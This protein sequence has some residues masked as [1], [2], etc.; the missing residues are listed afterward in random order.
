MYLKDLLIAASV[1]S[2]IGSKGSILLFG[3][4]TA[5]LSLWLT[6]A[7]QDISV[8]EVALSNLRSIRWWVSNSISSLGVTSSGAKSDIVWSVGEELVG[9][10]WV[11]T[12]AVTLGVD[13]GL[14]KRQ[15]WAVAVG[16][17]DTVLGVG[18][19]A[20]DDDVEFTSVLAGVLGG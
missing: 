3:V 6:I 14:T 13:G 9:H 17:W 11:D 4:Q 15:S 18:V 12:V 19:R 20:G 10:V 1:L 7:V 8:P 2:N 5:V 16:G